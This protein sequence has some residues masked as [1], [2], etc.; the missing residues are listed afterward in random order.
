MSAICPV[1]LK[2]Q[3]FP[4]PVGTSHLCQDR[5]FL[6]GLGTAGSAARI[7]ALQLAAFLSIHRRDQLEARAMDIE[8]D[9]GGN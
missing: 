2:Q 7:A 8:I 3:T 6:E 9:D 1:Y 4:D 5:T